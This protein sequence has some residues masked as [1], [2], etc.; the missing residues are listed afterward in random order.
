MAF[1]E[2][3]SKH[4]TS[5]LS[6]KFVKRREANGKQLAYIEGWH[7]IAEANRIFGFDAWDRETVS[8][9]CVWSGKSGQYFACAY[10]AKVR[11]SVRAGDILIAR[12]GSGSGEAKGLTPGQA[13]DMSLKAAETDAT[14][15]ALS[16]FGNLFGLALYD[17]DLAGVRGGHRFLD[18]QVH[19][20]P[21]SWPLHCESG[22]VIEIYPNNKAFADA[23]S[24]LIRAAITIEGLFG[25]WEHNVSLLATLSQED[26][27]NGQGTRKLVALL[28]SK[29][30]ELA[31]LGSESSAKQLD[32]D[33]P[34]REN[35]A[36]CADGLETK[37]DKNSLWIGE[38]KRIRSKEHLKFVAKQSCLICGRKPS[39]AHH[40]RYAQPRALSR[41]V[42]D[43]FVVPLCAIHHD[44][45]HR[46]GDEKQWWN[47]HSIDPLS[48]AAELWAAKGTP[49]K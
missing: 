8:E 36:L 33:T 48:V 6:P 20:K 37:I 28:K 2:Q 31:G 23:L 46:V 34:Q 25:L 43:E 12:E 5:K 35:G 44:A 1:T 38:P 7:A 15:R 45:L 26:K 32:S 41:K 21:P 10:T 47:K 49:I 17:R 16:T 11:I 22:Q 19:E 4:L 39:H 14:K 27:S 3:Q 29:A 18:G 24:K 13:H 30:Q 9:K 40:I 42:S